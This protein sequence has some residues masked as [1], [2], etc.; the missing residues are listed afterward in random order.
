MNMK[1]GIQLN[2]PDGWKGR[3]SV[4]GSAAD[5]TEQV[6]LAATAESG[7]FIDIVLGD[8]PQGETAQDQA[9]AN[10]METVGF[11]ED[12]PEDYNP[13]VKLKFNGKPAWGFDAYTED[14]RP[15][16]LI[17]QEVRAGI[18]AVIVF[19]TPDRD[20]LVELHIHIERNLRIRPLAEK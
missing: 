3:T 14:D 1:Y 7:S 10:Y 11:S 8:M 17:A 6:S 13:I 19:G 2:L 12:D 4:I 9:F 15:M 5:G 20:S 18:L 16:R